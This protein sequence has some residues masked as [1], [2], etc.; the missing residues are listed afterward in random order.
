MENKIILW[1][2]PLVAVILVI[3]VNYTFA[4]NNDQL[5]N[6]VNN[7]AEKY[8]SGNNNDCDAEFECN[9]PS[10]EQLHNQD[11]QCDGN[12]KCTNES[13]SNIVLCK[14]NSLCLFQYEGPFEL[15]NPY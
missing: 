2:I 4:D 8:D 14:D 10:L 11:N 15:L 13:F 5:D 7:K 12:A 6:G 3:H 9:I 1:I